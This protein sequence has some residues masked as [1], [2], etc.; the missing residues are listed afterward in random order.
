MEPNS[1]IDVAVFCGGII[2]M[3]ERRESQEYESKADGGC[4]KPDSDIYTVFKKHVKEILSIPN[5]TGVNISFKYINKVK[6]PY[7]Q[8]SVKEKPKANET[9]LEEW[10]PKEICNWP[11]EIIEDEPYF[12]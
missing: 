10:L 9:S 4:C 8:V 7:I 12:V 11:V 6:Q 2:M 3:S 5:V 1:T